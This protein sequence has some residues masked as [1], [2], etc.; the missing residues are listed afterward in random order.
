MTIKDNKVTVKGSYKNSPMTAAGDY[1]FAEKDG[2]ADF[3][4]N[5]TEMQIQNG[6]PFTQQMLASELQ[7]TIQPRSFKGYLKW[8]RVDQMEMVVESYGQDSHIQFHKES[9]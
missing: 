6:N 5:I 1:T 9:S 8:D 7:N 4:F 2:E 3:S